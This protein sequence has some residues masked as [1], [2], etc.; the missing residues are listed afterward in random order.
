MRR[1]ALEGF[2]V[3]RTFYFLAFVQGLIAKCRGTRRILVWQGT[4]AVSTALALLVS[5]LWLIPWHGR[6]DGPATR[7]QSKP[8]QDSDHTAEE[9]AQPTLPPPASSTAVSAVPSQILET[10]TAP[11]EAALQNPVPPVEKHEAS[12][13][14]PALQ[15]HPPAISKEPAE[16]LDAQAMQELITRLDA[17]RSTPS[18]HLDTKAMDNLLARLE[19]SDK[20]TLPTPPRSK[21]ARK[22]GAKSL[23]RATP[24]RRTPSSAPPPQSNP[25]PFIPALAS[26]FPDASKPA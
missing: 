17:A 20:T 15:D 9:T 7:P 5:L 10:G 13:A 23:L 3:Y 24:G 26:Q 4:L 19:S 25:V 14:A 18:E 21:V 16:V 8:A 12:G 11:G 2:E 6:P 22:R 1:E